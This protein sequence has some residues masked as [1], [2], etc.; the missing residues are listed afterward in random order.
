MMTKIKS[1][2]GLKDFL[3]VHLPRDEFAKKIGLG[4]PSSSMVLIEG[5]EGSGRSVVC[6]RL[7]YGLLEN[8]H[9]VTYISTELT[10]K[11]FINQMYSMKYNIGSHLLSNRLKFIPV[12]PIIGDRLPQEDYLGILMENQDLYSSTVTV[13]DSMGEMLNDKSGPS[14][15]DR[16]LEFFKKTV[17]R[18]RVI[19]MTIKKGQPLVERLRQ[20]VDLFFELELRSSSYGI[21]HLLKVRRYLKA[22]GKV[23]KMIEF[24]VEPDVGL[25]IEI[26]EVSG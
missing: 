4:I 26:T 12:L 18:D 19:I 11:D 20:S 8:G 9:S 14:D 5:E 17:H 7:T 23:D 10:L 13:I 6:Q 16:L 3:V 22:R 15:I 2:T 25:I 21:R 1:A 24:R